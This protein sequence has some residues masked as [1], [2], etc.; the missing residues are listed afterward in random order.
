MKLGVNQT[1]EYWRTRMEKPLNFPFRI[2]WNNNRIIIRKKYCSGV[3]DLFSLGH[4]CS[5]I[6]YAQS[7]NINEHTR[8]LTFRIEMDSSVKFVIYVTILALLFILIV[9]IASLE[10]LRSLLVAG[11]IV[12]VVLWLNLIVELGRKNFVNN[13]DE[14]INI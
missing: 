8:T 9:S 13:W 14:H 1:P 4:F 11:A 10:W 7:K 2:S 12:L 3:L 5:R 6:F